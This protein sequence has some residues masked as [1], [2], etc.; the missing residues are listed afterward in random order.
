MEDRLKE[1]PITKICPKCQIN[2]VA[3]KGLFFV[4][5]PKKYKAACT[6]CPYH[7]YEYVPFTYIEDVIGS[8][9]LIEKYEESR[10]KENDEKMRKGFDGWLNGKNKDTKNGL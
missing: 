3:I 8:K 2:L 4:T 10:T 6:N 7:I 9:A 5:Q 1:K